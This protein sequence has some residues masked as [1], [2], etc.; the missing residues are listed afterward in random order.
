MIHFLET[1]EDKRRRL[2]SNGHFSDSALC[3]H[4]EPVSRIKVTQ[5]ANHVTCPRC[6]DKLPR[7]HT[8]LTAYRAGL[9]EAPTPPVYTGNWTDEDWAKWV[10]PTVLTRD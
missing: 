7:I 2:Q 8:R 10:T 6:L 3:G 1:Q 5:R 4:G 9:W